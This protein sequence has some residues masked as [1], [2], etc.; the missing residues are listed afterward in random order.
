MEDEK[1]LAYGY[2]RSDKQF[3]GC[4]IS[5]NKYFIDNART[6][7]R[8]LEDAMLTVREGVVVVVMKLSDFGSGARAKQVRE[9]IEEQ[10]GS[11]EVIGESAQKLGRGRKTNV[12]FTDDELDWACAL[13]NSPLREKSA[14][15]AR[16]QAKTGQAPNRDQM[17]YLCRRKPQRQKD[18]GK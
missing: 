13:W 18:T 15:L 8:E 9:Y 4:R 17:N 10:G 3:S 11:I 1:R 14:V 7:R 6:N 12:K 2:N 16:I 5:P